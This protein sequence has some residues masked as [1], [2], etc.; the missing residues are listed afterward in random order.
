MRPS[1]TL[2]DLDCRATEGSARLPNWTLNAQCNRRA[3]KSSWRLR[4]ELRPSFLVHSKP[5]QPLHP[6]GAQGSVALSLANTILT[7]WD[8]RARTKR[9]RAR[10]GRFFDF[11]V[12]RQAS[13]KWLGS[14]NRI[15]TEAGRLC[16]SAS[17]SEAVP[18]GSQDL[19]SPRPRDNGS[20]GGGG[21]P[22]RAGRSRAE[23]IIGW[24][25][26]GNCIYK[27]LFRDFWLKDF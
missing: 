9:W 15:L 16:S 12:S 14:G 18:L 22:V 24:S 27:W 20:G 4:Q 21:E 8:R 2:T 23:E 10:P 11:S 3:E 13:I 5:L 6:A 17:S 19:G 7:V 25:S 1:A 26:G